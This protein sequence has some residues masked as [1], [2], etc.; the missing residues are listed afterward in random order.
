MKHSQNS[1]RRTIR[2]YKSEA[3]ERSESSRIVISQVRT[4][5]TSKNKLYQP[6]H[7][8]S[9]SNTD[10]TCKYLLT[11][12]SP[13]FGHCQINYFGIR[14]LFLILT[15]SARHFLIVN[16]LI[17][18]FF[19]SAIQCICILYIPHGNINDSLTDKLLTKDQSRKSA[20]QRASLENVRIHKYPT[21]GISF[22]VWVGTYE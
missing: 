6:I 12:N 9:S 3:S 7:I 21:P 19:K 8:Y 13:L 4:T 17:G 2:S 22:N 5:I 1:L 18:H 15:Y 16:Y 14:L 11:P 20:C 10:V